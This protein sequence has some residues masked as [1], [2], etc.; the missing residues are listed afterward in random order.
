MPTSP[1][2]FLSKFNTRGFTSRRG[3]S[4]FLRRESPCKI[5]AMPAGPRE[6]SR[7]SKL[8]SACRERS[9]S[10]PNANAPASPMRRRAKDRCGVGGASVETPFNLRKDRCRRAAAATSDAASPSATPRQSTSTIR[11]AVVIAAATSRPQH[12]DPSK[13][14]RSRR[15]A[16]TPSLSPS[17]AGQ[18][19][20]SRSTET[21][22]VEVAPSLSAFNS[23]S[24][25]PTS[26]TSN[27]SNRS[28]RHC[29]PAS[30]QSGG[31]ACSRQ[32][33]WRGYSDR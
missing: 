1:T 9:K 5:A 4:P 19:F 26:S 30:W 17:K 16:V 11:A 10:R 6:Q 12:L 29:W 24:K 8:S 31:S 7:R 13:A 22:S 18:R 14:L 15:A 3:G 25:E 28:N 33:K 23:K 32:I 2:S 20:S 21:S 27:A